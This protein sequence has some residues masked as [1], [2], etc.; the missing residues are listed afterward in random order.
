[1]KKL[2]T[3]SII[4]CALVS[5]NSSL[6]SMA[7]GLLRNSKIQPYARWCHTQRTIGSLPA[8][9]IHNSSA[10]E[11]MADSRIL[12]ENMHQRNK[13]LASLL[14]KE[15]EKNQDV[16]VKI[17]QQNSVAID[18]TFN[19]EPLDPVKLKQLE[20]DIREYAEHKVGFYSLF[21]GNKTRSHASTFPLRDLDELCKRIEATEK[22]LLSLKK[23]LSTPIEKLRVAEI[24]LL[25]LR[26]QLEKFRKND[27]FTGNWEIIE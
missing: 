22:T 15:I 12:L 9:N 23:D 8:K 3:L 11:I 25:N 13:K 26:E 19:R 14:Q 20:E 27:A 5:S 17:R 1:M 24:D 16:L 6:G 4:V 18:H 10:E 7:L 2:I 21:N